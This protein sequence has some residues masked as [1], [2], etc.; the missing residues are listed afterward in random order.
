MA[1]DKRGFARAACLLVGLILVVSVAASLLVLIWLPSLAVLALLAYSFGCRHGIDADHIAAIDNVTR[2]LVANGTGRRT[3]MVGVWF[4][5][6]HCTVVVLLCAAVVAGARTSS[7]QFEELAALGETVGPW[8]AA[9][10][11][12]AIGSINIYTARDLIRQWKDRQARGHEHEIASLVTGCCPALIDAVDRPSRVFWIGLLFGLG[13]DTATEIAML[14]TTAIAMPDVPPL[15]ALVLPLLFAAGMA[16]VDSLNAI[17]MLWAQEWAA[18]E[19]PLHRLYFSLF[20]TLASATLALGIGALEALGQ[21]ATVPWVRAA[22][23][24]WL[25]PCWEATSW[26]SDHLEYLGMGA[27]G[28]FLFGITLAVALAHRCVPSREAV[29]TETQTKLRESLLSYVNKGEYIVRFE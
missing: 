21:L 8:V 12:L 5:L 24:G 11:L 7:R 16:L 17:L 13:L 22:S 23:P 3:M 6:G 1:T 27:V 4:S 14:T 2:R 29:E 9:V 15:C 18:D 19:G 10:V 20:L 28:A 26:L 25:Q